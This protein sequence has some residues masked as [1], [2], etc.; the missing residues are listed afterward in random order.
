MTKYCTHINYGTID[1]KTELLLEDDAATVN[2]G[3]DW[4]MP[5]LDQIDE[6][7]NSAYTTTE[8][9]TL[10]GVYGRNI[11]SKTNGKS[12]FLPA[13]GARDEGLLDDVGSEGYYWTRSLY[14]YSYAA[15]D[16]Y[17][18][19]G[20]NYIGPRYDQRRYGFSVRPVRK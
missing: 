17:F 9:T 13:A 10:N 8:W 15:Y 18:Q 6:L 20:P 3:S 16:L 1:N 2:W 12:L 19:S 5:S 14:S 7:Y 11:T 4:R